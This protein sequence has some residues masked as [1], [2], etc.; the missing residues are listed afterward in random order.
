MDSW[1]RI[2][3]S[4]TVSLHT[5]TR[6]IWET[7][8]CF[9]DP[10]YEE[11]VS[12]CTASVAIVSSK[13]IFVVCSFQAWLKTRNLP[14][15]GNAGDSRSVLGVKGRAKPLSFDHKPQNEGKIWQGSSSWYMN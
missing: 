1:P 8:S 10:R 4:S 5:Y 12:G 14:G 6:G 13:K 7:D 15:Q 2:E 9:V 3:R 11:E